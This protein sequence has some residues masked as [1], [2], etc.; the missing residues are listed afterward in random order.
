LIRNFI[1]ISG[2]GG[3][4]GMEIGAGDV[5]PV[6]LTVFLLLRSGRLTEAV[7]YMRDCICNNEF[8]RILEEYE[9]SGATKLPADIENKLRLEYRRT[10]Q[11][12]AR[13]PY[14]K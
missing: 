6:W 13:D 9:K 2:L 7:S 3:V 4:S 11:N 1:N 14:K 8:A 5:G 12:S 10:L